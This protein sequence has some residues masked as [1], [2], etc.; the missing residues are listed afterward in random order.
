MKLEFTSINYVV[1]TDRYLRETSDPLVCMIKFHHYFTM[2]WHNLKVYRTMHAMHRTIYLVN[3]LY[4]EPV[5]KK[6]RV[7]EKIMEFTSTR[8][9]IPRKARLKPNSSI[10]VQRDVSMN[11]EEPLA[12]EEYYEC[13]S[14]SRA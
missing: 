6:R 5:P 12:S 14:K 10:R 9:N 1:A 3:L 4:W 8:K 13:L 7:G 11:G 2:G